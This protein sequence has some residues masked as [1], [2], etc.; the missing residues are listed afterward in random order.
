M[1]RLG[2]KIKINTH[3]RTKKEEKKK[4]RNKKEKKNKRRKKKKKKEKTM[5]PG[6]ETNNTERLF[7]KGYK[8]VPVPEVGWTPRDTQAHDKKKGKQLKD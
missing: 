2:V 6:R 3:T 5:V 7:I 4:K 8:Y 1:S